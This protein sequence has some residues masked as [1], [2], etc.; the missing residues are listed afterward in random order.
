MNFCET[1][2][3]FIYSNEEDTNM[4]YAYLRARFLS[5]Q[6]FS[7]DKTQW[8]TGF[9]PDYMRTVIYEGRK[10]YKGYVS[11]KTDLWLH[12][13]FDHHLNDEVAVCWVRSKAHRA[14][15]L[16]LFFKSSNVTP[17]N[18]F[19]TGKLRA[20]PD[21]C[22]TRCGLPGVEDSLCHAITK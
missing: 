1:K 20:L 10:R 15:L 5:N 6:D 7:F 16:N 18:V 9:Q 14:D 17:K 11:I 13:A 3:Y 12:E 4:Y 2:T 19:L 21:D 22:I 8:T